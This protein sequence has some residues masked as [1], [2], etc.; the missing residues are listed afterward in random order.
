MQ[1]GDTELTGKAQPMRPHVLG[2]EGL[3][4]SWELEGDRESY[5]QG[6]KR[7]VKQVSKGLKETRLHQQDSRE[8]ASA[9]L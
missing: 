6:G 7:Q 1:T 2:P 8:P 5:E 9:S 3:S 4:K